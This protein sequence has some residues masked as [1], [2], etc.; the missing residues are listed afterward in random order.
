MR[1]DVVTRY[2]YYKKFLHLHLE[3]TRVVILR[4]TYRAAGTQNTLYGTLIYAVRKG[5]R[6]IISLKEV[7]M[8]VVT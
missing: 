3:S 2:K 6:T 8:V 7:Q 4:L 1:Y 5:I